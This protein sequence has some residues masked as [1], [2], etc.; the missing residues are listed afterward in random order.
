MAAVA[1]EVGPAGVGHREKQRQWEQGEAAR[2]W[3][4]R[5]AQEQGGPW[6]G[7]ERTGGDVER[8]GFVPTSRWRDLEEASLAPP[9]SQAQSAHQRRRPHLPRSPKTQQ[10]A[11]GNQR[12]MSSAE[13]TQKPRA[14]CVPTKPKK[15]ASLPVTG[16]SLRKVALHTSPVTLKGKV[17][18]VD[19]EAQRKNLQLL[20]EE[21]QLGLPHYLRNKV[22]EL[23][24]TA[25]ELNALKLWCLCQKYILYRHFQSLR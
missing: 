7:P 1:K 8:M 11:P 10:P 2:G 6:R 4:W 12:T 25:V 19:V 5:L 9:Q 23:T 22:R 20:T 3:Q 15:T 17:Y 18:H 24:T 21:D 13:F 16:T 14:R